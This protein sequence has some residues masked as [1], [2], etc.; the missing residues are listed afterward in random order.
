[1]R[2]EVAEL[3]KAVNSMGKQIDLL[4]QRQTGATPTPAGTNRPDRDIIV[5][6]FR[7]VETLQPYSMFY[8]RPT[9]SFQDLS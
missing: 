2:E 5:E 7:P 4:I 8:F 1:M 6:T 3:V 9:K